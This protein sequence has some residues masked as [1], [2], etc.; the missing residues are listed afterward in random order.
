MSVER[1]R[2]LLG[3]RRQGVGNVA[4]AGLGVVTPFCSCSAVPVFI[5]FV[6]AGVPLGVTLSF[7]IA[8][9]DGQ[10]GRD[11]A[12]VRPVRVEDH[13]AVHR[14]RARHR[15]RRRHGPRAD[16]PRTVGRAVRVRDQAPR[17]GHRPLP[18][19]R[20]GTTGCRWHA[21]K[22][23]R[24]CARCGRTCSSASASAPSSTAGRPR[25]GS[26]STPP[27]GWG[28]PLAV[29]D[30]RAA[31]LERRRRAP[32]RRSAARQRAPDGHRA[33]VH[34]ERRRPL[35]AGDDPPPPGAQTEADRHLRRR[36]RAPGIM[37]TGFLFNAVL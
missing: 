7:L 21:K 23:S 13:R 34:D 29:A 25:T 27:A 17:Q 31:V 10:R 28:V 11:R 30:R 36:R 6:A 14:L 26:P 22:S 32:A 33:R 19:A 37:L 5:G 9:P 18:R 16:E 15:H 8:S 1:T 35:A 3:G 4:A 12:A 20:A 24:S 2:A